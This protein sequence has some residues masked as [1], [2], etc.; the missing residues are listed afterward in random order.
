[1]TLQSYKE[2]KLS[3]FDKLNI[4]SAP[5]KNDKNGVLT[6]IVDISEVKKFISY[7]IDEIEGCLPQDFDY[8]Y[9]DIKCTCGTCDKIKA[10]KEILQEFQDNINKL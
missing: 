9:C 7:L 8:S 4:F 1:M 10:R 3:E 5:I 2:R 6:F